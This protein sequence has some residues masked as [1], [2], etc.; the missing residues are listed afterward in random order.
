MSA[1]PSASPSPSWIWLPSYDD[2]IDPGRFV[3]FRR[4]FKLGQLPT[5]PC[6]VKVSAD[7]RYR[8]FVNGKS[9]SF[10]P[11]KSYLERWYYETVDIAPFLV[12][13][14]NVLAAK[15]LRFS[16]NHA[17]NSNMIRAALPG[18]WLEGVVGVLDF[19]QRVSPIF[20]HRHYT[21]NSAGGVSSHITC[22]EGSPRRVHQTCH[23]G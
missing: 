7:T 10:G 19:P 15:V 21:D 20:V 11:C 22:L 4:S 1:P 23:T 5:S 9:V 18:F 8:L 12:Q 16:P 6:L 3:L 13:G 17:G 14:H 2:T